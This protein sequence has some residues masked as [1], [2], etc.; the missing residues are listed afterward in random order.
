MRDLKGVR[1]VRNLV[2][3]YNGLPKRRERKKGMKTVGREWEFEGRDEWMQIRE[4]W[5]K[6]WDWHERRR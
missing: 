3:E 2:R 6:E 4:G 5:L 1:K